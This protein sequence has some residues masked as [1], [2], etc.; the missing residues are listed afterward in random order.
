MTNFERKGLQEIGNKY[1]EYSNLRNVKFTN[2]YSSSSTQYNP[3]FVTKVADALGGAAYGMIPFLGQLN[4]DGPSEGSYIHRNNFTVMSPDGYI[5]TGT[6]EYTYGEFVGLG[7][8]SYN[9]STQAYLHVRKSAVKDDVFLL[10][11]SNVEYHKKYP[12]V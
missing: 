5:Y 12:F 4:H 8:T 2:Q 6:L 7:G 1:L 11:G 3:N 9:G 10:G